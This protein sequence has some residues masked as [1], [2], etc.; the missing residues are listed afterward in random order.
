MF[1]TT[2]FIGLMGAVAFAVMIA[3]FVAHPAGTQALA[4]AGTK[5]ESTALN[6]ELG[7][8]S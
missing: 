1:R 4:N 6:A 5:A 7:K 8:T 2:T 3:D